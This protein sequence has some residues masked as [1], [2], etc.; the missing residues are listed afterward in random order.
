MILPVPKAL[1]LP[2]LR[3]VLLF[4]GGYRQLQQPLD[5][6]PVQYVGPYAGVLETYTHVPRQRG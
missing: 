3:A 2:D 4:C 5:L 1:S 6:I